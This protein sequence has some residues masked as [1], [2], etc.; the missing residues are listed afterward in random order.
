MH[1]N[2]PVRLKIR[3]VEIHIYTLFLFVG[4]TLGIISGVAVG[5]AAGENALR[6]HVA[7]VLLTIPALLGSR[8]LYVVTHRKLYTEHARLWS[9]GTGGAA[10]YGGL[11]LAL[12]CSW[13]VLRLLGLSFGAFWDAA[14]VTILVGMIF[15]KLG[16]LCRGCCAGRPTSGWVGLTLP[17]ARGVSCRR[18]PTQLLECG[19]ATVLLG[20]LM[21]WG[22]HPFQ[23]ARFLVGLA[24]YATARIV[25]GSTRE[26][27]DRVA[28]INLYSAI[29]GVL[30][31]T[32]V[33]ILASCWWMD[34][35]PDH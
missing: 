18:V 2:L 13:P 21:S 17:N 3:G 22:G 33:A 7:L 11:L 32:S 6:L 5:R 31:V 25:L 9:R 23:G 16:C 8:L 35:A 15:T 34:L 27:V 10:L 26:S 4:I 14:T 1:Q 12:A 19:L 30:V 24:L 29:S 28:G 20:G